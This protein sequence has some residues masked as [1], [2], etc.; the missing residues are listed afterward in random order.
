MDE[1]LSPVSSTY[2][3]PSGDEKPLEHVNRTPPQAS[4]VP[5]NFEASSIEDVIKALKSEPDYDVLISAL[6]LLSCDNQK[7]RGFKIGS[8][9]P[10]AAQVIQTLVTEIVPNYWTLLKESCVE[11][12]NADLDLLLNALR[13]LTG[14]NAILLRIR[15]HI[16]EKKGE[17]PEAKRSDVLLNLKI[18][19]EVLSAI[20]EGHGRVMGIW[21]AVSD[22]E[23]VVKRRI[24]SKEFVNVL[25]SGRII[26]LSAEAEAL[27]SQDRTKLSWIADGLEY[28]RW[29]A[30]NILAWSKEAQEPEGEKIVADLLS[31]VMH[32]GYSE[33][34]IKIIVSELINE[35]QRDESLQ[36]IFNHLPYSQ[37]RTIL[38]GLL[39]S[40][41]ETY[42]NDLGACG[43]PSDESIISAAAGVV[44]NLVADEP[45]YRS[46]LITWLTT[47]TGAGLGDAVGIRRAILAVLA[48]NQ[49][50]IITVFSKSLSQFGDYLYIRHTPVLQQEVHAQV[51]LLSAG[52]LQRL[53]PLKL[54]L[55]VRGGTFMQMISKR[56]EASQ[57]RARLL[58]MI[59]GEALSQL[60]EKSDKR[61]DFKMEETKSE[62]ALWYK[63][64]VELS[65]A[66]GSTD[67]LKS[68][69]L[70]VRDDRTKLHRQARKPAST[71]KPASS[72]GTTRVIIEEVD[73]DEEM[74]DDIIPLKKPDDDDEDSDNDPET[75]KR[76]RPKAPVYVRS[77][78]TYL[79]DTENYDRQKLAVTT[80]PTLIRRKANFGTEVKEHAEELA[81]L[82]V[83]LQDTY[84]IENFD[85]L[86]LQSMIAIIV[87]Q[88]QKMGPW[89]GKTFFDGDYSVALRVSV[90][91]VL[92]L[93]ARE[94][95]GFITSEFA[96]AAS[97]PSKMLPER[98][99]KLYV[100]DVTSG[101][102]LQSSSTLKALPLTALDT[103][104]KSL[105]S[106]FMAPIA[107][108]AADTATGPDVLKL[109]TF[110]S[111]LEQQNTSVSKGRE[112]PRIRAIPNTTAQ[113]I[114][115]SFFFP[116]SARFQSA[117]RSSA[118]RARGIIF[119]PFLLS[120]YLK[121][122]ALLLHAAG[123]S[124]LAL[125]DMTTE[126]WG[127]LLGSSVRAHAVGDLGVT[128][129]MLFALLTMLEVNGDR[130]R[131]I[132]QTMSREVIETQEWVVQVF[133]G[134]RGEDGS[135]E[136]AEVKA[137]AAGCLVRI[138]EGMEKYRMLLMGDMIG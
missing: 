91:T 126:L 18:D 46:H 63:S 34:V 78:I 1:L 48:P 13:S 104:S 83:G 113:L 134:I 138:N 89:F 130:M 90:L 49:D 5:S 43:A 6:R 98:M 85:D 47:A 115:T 31:K 2:Y 84:D 23:D 52:Y 75:V 129:A 105:T 136:E 12:G 81:T 119:Q 21:T 99:E 53:A 7:L 11:D 71:P 109:S 69:L 102:Q 120:L 33:T 9:G 79:R 50:D 77:L 30:H 108:N 61:L 80:A 111:R 4:S 112:K 128:H 20:L 76:D 26:S 127:I 65:D 62:E 29:L 97:F 125:P 37:Q 40:L 137:L 117:I 59:V 27:I 87:A 28:S 36:A 19:L 73:S 92:G 39:K 93:G 121:T 94:L 86:R 131:D 25:G 68:S 70:H 88:P 42:L 8:P 24:M 103:I 22:G 118:G 133:H 110:R 100:E 72:T 64:L 114:A 96:S 41:S 55:Q 51:L 58:G 74:E 45:K 60:V 106:D 14:L 10:E 3:K 135:G 82:L 44:T 95:A 66:V 132:C 35:H 57:T 101:N 32:L 56:L 123:P 16:Q 122:L 17:T 67:P 116:L 124:T 15:S 107:A 54:A 38:F